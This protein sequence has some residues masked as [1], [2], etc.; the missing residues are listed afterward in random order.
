MPTAE[1]RTWTLV[2]EA[3][4]CTPATTEPPG[5]T[6]LTWA[7]GDLAVPGSQRSLR[8]HPQKNQTGTPLCEG[9]CKSGR[10]NIYFVADII[11]QLMH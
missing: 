10:E 9:L 3:E 8:Q 5:S 7:H 6:D 2:P 11:I 4:P 1:E